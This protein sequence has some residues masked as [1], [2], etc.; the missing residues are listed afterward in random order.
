VP[1]STDSGRLTESRVFSRV[2]A[3]IS[4][5]IIFCV[6][7]SEAEQVTSSLVFVSAIVMSLGAGLARLYS[8][9]AQFGEAPVKA[10]AIGGLLLLA[11]PVPILFLT[12]SLLGPNGAVL[13]V[14]GAFAA[15]LWDAGRYLAV[16]RKSTNRSDKRNSG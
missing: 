14:F 13:Y 16:L 1:I 6:T 10:Q 12:Q 3:A 2:S 7:L 8:S 5:I 9:F 11:P 4:L 15:A